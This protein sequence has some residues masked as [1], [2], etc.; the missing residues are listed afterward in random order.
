VWNAKEQ[1]LVRT[2][3][4]PSLEKL[5]LSGTGLGVFCYL[6][7]LED[8]D[9]QTFETIG[10]TVTD[11]GWKRLVVP[12]PNSIYDQVTSRKLE[13]SH[14]YAEKRVKLSEIYATRIFN[15]GFFDKLQVNEWLIQDVRL[16]KY[17]PLT[18]R[19]QSASDAT[20]FVQRFP[21]TFF[22]P[23]HGSLGLGIIRVTKNLD[24][25]VSYAIKRQHITPI[26][27][28]VENSGKAIRRLQ[29]RLKSRPYLMQQGITLASYHDRPFDIRILLQRD[30]SGV[31]RR[32]KVFARV[33]KAGDFTSNLSSGGEALPVNTVLQSV[34]PSV[35][36]RKT[37]H[38]QIRKVSNLITEVIERES[39]KQF[40]ELGVDVGVD[41][42]GNVWIIEVNSKPWKSATTEKG[43]QDLVDLA[44]QRPIQ[45]AIHL[46][47]QP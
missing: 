21:T 12:L 13:R 7:R 42:N 43:R 3:Q 16:R 2:R 39:G 40:G 38:R 35:E 4:L 11:E 23:V 22:K 5:V 24:G 25:S 30:G 28:K 37:C 9:F 20:A 15:D 29:K 32:T 46:A 33:A 14:S 31:W 47:E 45:Y 34:F 27:E 19:Y 26:E 8:V 36:S 6:F 10:Y 44:F 1:A 41:E 18:A 17:V